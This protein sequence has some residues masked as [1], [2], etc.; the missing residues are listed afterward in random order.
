MINFECVSTSIPLGMRHRLVRAATF[1]EAA[2]ALFT[3]AARSLYGRSALVKSIAL[4]HVTKDETI[5]RYTGWVGYDP[6]QSLCT[7]NGKNIQILI[8]K[9]VR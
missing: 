2:Q 6:G 1:A 7:E 8:R 9:N 3:I 5:C 4:E